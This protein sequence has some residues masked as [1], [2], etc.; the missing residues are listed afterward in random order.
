[1]EPT[2]ALQ[3]G[4]L[5]FSSSAAA[6]VRE[7]E[8][9][10]RARIW[11]ML[12][13]LGCHPGREMIEEILQE[14]YCRIFGDALRRW[15]GTSLR[16]LLAYLGVIAERT[17][18]DHFR[19]AQAHKRNLRE[20]YLGRRRI[21]QIADPR[22]PEQ[23]LL[24][25]ENQAVLLRSCHDLP[26][27]GGRRRN[28]WVARLAFLEGLTNQEIASAAGGRLSPGNVACLV[29]R[30]RRRLERGGFGKGSRPDRGARRQGSRRRKG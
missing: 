6:I 25:A 1:M 24:H 26:E 14:T 19:G 20:V 10:L 21:E 9:V 18:L 27:R 7:H 15:R 16:E 12:E 8:G 29:H 3:P 13:R 5:S 2:T 23:D 22:D 17:A 30:L 4:S 11:G 28:A